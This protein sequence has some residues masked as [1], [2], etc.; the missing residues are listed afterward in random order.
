METAS[1]TTRYGLAVPIKEEKKVVVE[2]N[3]DHHKEVADIITEKVGNGKQI[4]DHNSSKPLSP[5]QNDL[6]M[7]NKQVFVAASRRSSSMDIEL[8]VSPTHKDEDEELESAKVEMGEVRQENERLKTI[9]SRIVKDYQS[10]QMHFFDIVQHE[11]AKKTTEDP[12]PMHEDEEHELISLSLGR[13]S[14]ERKKDEKT[15]SHSSKS[16][17]DEEGLALGLDCKF[18]GP[19]QGLPIEPATNLSPEDSLGETK[20]EEA[21]EQWPPSKI[22]KTMRSADDDVL[23]QPPVKKARVSVR[24]RCD[25]PTVSILISINFLHSPFCS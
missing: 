21:G 11:Q 7:N 2:S 8:K 15:I 13:N 1:S 25:T 10:L 16:K 3:A 12:T 20:E 9:L 23:Q 5:S 17:P 18:E 4:N 14:S 24:A 6:S 19:N 22:L